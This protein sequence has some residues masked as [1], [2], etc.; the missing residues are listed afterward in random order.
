MAI[1]FK[2]K[3]CN[4][5]II[6]N[7]LNPGELVKCYS[8]GTMNSIPVDDKAYNHCGLAYH[9]KGEYNLAIR[10]YNKAI[11]LNPEFTEAYN[12]RGITFD[13]MAEYYRAIRNYN[14]A[15][16][17]NPE[18]AEAYNNRGIT[19]HEMGEYDL[20]IKDYNKAIEL[21]PENAESYYNRGIA[22]LK[23]GYTKVFPCKNCNNDIFI[24]IS[25][26]GELVKCYSCG[27]MN[28]IPEDAKEIIVE[29]E[30]DN[31]HKEEKKEVVDIQNA[32]VSDTTGKSK[33]SKIRRLRALK[34]CLGLI[35]TVVLIVI[36][37]ALMETP[38][39]WCLRLLAPFACVVVLIMCFRKTPKELKAE[40]DNLD[41]KIAAAYLKKRHYDDAIT[42]TAAHKEI[43]MQNTDL[44]YTTGKSKSSKTRRLTKAKKIWVLVIAIVFNISLAWSL[45][46]SNLDLWAFILLLIA[47]AC[48]LYLSFLLMRKK[49][50]KEWQAE[51]DNL[52]KLRQKAKKEMENIPERIAE[53]SAK[54]QP[55]VK[56]DFET[57]LLPIF[58]KY[59]GKDS[60]HVAPDIKEKKLLNAFDSC[61]VPDFEQIAALV[62]CTVMGSAKDCLL[63]GSFGIY[64]H[65][66]WTGY[67]PGSGRIFYTDFP[68][69]K[70]AKRGESA[71]WLDSKSSLNIA[72]CGMGPKEL[73]SLL[74]EIQS[75]SREKLTPTKAE[76][77]DL[78]SGA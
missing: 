52:E 53:V 3:N 60:F 38:M 74:C 65:N 25:K 47:I 30:T 78:I 9:E 27:T 45:N 16:E 43:D 31:K 5:D 59:R 55:T 41:Y 6:T 15:I 54:H 8:C 21:S 10:N 68:V 62:D 73:I 72:G 23:K 34:I 35:T 17:L 14:K 64:F 61:K 63:I 58:E 7:S 46:S 49:T 40:K 2:C 20:A 32:G 70:V 71:V 36:A 29:E 11:E 13:E 22:Y 1:E 76:E 44:S 69:G 26:P 77:E 28:S 12:N 33:S 37:V 42:K 19:Y 4:K 24:K 66:D 56:L 50:S 51:I 39:G 57:V 75:A 67:P 48:C 18:F